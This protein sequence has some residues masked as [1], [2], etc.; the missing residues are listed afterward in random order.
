MIK[1]LAIETRS[2]AITPNEVCG[3]HLNE[4]LRAIGK[5][6]AERITQ[7]FSPIDGACP[8]RLLWEFGQY[9]SVME[10]RRLRAGEDDLLL[11]W[12]LEHDRH[13]LIS[14]GDPT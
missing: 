3:R 6:Q 12:R 14:W 4:E 11:V 8:F 10:N 9:P 2:C 1:L 13:I 5:H 7:H